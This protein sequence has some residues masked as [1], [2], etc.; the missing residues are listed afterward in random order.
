MSSELE[1]Y[2]EI[3]CIN[4]LSI[5]ECCEQ[6]NIRREDLPDAFSV[7]GILSDRDRLII[8]QL[9]LLLDKD[10]SAIETCKT[11]EQYEEYLST[12]VDGIYRGHAQKSITL[13]KS[14][15]RKQRLRY[16]FGILLL[17]FFA[18][19]IFN[20]ALATISLSDEMH[21]CISDE[22]KCHGVVFVD[23]IFGEIYPLIRYS[24]NKDDSDNYG[25]IGLGTTTIYNPNIELSESSMITF[26]NSI[27]SKR[28][29]AGLMHSIISILS[30]FLIY[31]KLIR[32]KDLNRN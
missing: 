25:W 20:I 22:N 2:M 31:K 23:D 13:L 24:Q 21:I 6:L 5:T 14:E 9:A 12:Q 32:K 4:T 26:G 16:Y 1:K 29:I 19:H 7:F 15:A 17:A 3:K 10:K 8:E 28:R 27:I 18:I 11:I 30:S